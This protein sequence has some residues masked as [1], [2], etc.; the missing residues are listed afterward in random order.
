MPIEVGKSAPD[1]T[2]NDQDQ[3]P[4][5]LSSLRGKN[6][7]L[8]FFPFAWSP[9]CQG[10]NSCLTTDLPQ[11]QDKGTEVFGI[12]ADSSWTQKAW[13]TSLKL[14]HKLLSDQHREVCKKYGLFRNDLNCS[15]RATVIVDKKGVVRYVK[16]QPILEARKND[17]ILQALAKLS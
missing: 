9:V 12:S 3:K 5:T 4:V 14:N 10:E 13:H 2:L 8:A 11:F 1:F 7:I 6:V 16:V 15:E 17:E